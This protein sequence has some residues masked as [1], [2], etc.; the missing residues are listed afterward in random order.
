MVKLHIF[1]AK[2]DPLCQQLSFSKKLATEIR[3]AHEFLRMRAA[4][5]ARAVA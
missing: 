1:L 4:Q 2:T 3:F 5:A